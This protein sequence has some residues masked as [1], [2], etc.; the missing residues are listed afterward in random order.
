MARRRL[1]SSP[2]GDVAAGPVSPPQPRYLGFAAQ[3]RLPE[4]SLLLQEPQSCPA[5]RAV[6]IGPYSAAR[7][8]EHLGGGFKFYSV[9]K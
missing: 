9:L 3:V 8:K 2:A 1:G 5:E 7:L 6:E 4:P